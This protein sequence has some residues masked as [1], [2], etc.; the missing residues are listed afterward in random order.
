[1]FENKIQLNSW[2][3]LGHIHLSKKDYGFFNNLKHQIQDHKPITSN[4]SKLF[5][6][7]LVKYQRQLSKSGYA[8]EKLTSL[9]WNHEVVDTRQEFLDAKI[10]LVD[11]CIEIQSPF[12]TAFIQN[13]R[14]IR[15]NTF[16]WVKNKRAY[17]SDFYSFSLKLAIEYVT[18][19]YDSVKLCPAIEEILS[20]TKDLE[21][22]MYWEPTLV[23]VHNYFYIYGIN[24]SL[25]EAT[26]NIV[27][28]DDPKTLFLLSQ[29]GVKI[30]ESITNNDSLLMFSSNYHTTVDLDDTENLLRYLKALEVDQVLLGRDL[31]YNKKVGHELVDK[32]KQH[33]INPITSVMDAKKRV[34]SL[35]NNRVDLFLDKR[36]ISKTV[37]I[38]NSRP[39]EVS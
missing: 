25:Y 30:H 12:N 13:F 19:Y 22:H 6:K 18:K 17:K 3:I 29:H 10:S 35:S 1:M 15:N 23:K 32:F 20:S 36:H 14:K 37:V 7:L 2:L 21:N 24:N 28:N 16:I 34:I 31:I 9:K 27:L 38:T 8:V 33:G 5:D 4:Q 39:I 11:G 26:K